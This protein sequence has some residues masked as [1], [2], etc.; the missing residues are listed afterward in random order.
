[1]IP[2]SKQ[3]EDL[4]SFVWNVIIYIYSIMMYYIII[5]NLNLPGFQFV[6]H[7]FRHCPAMN[8][9]KSAGFGAKHSCGKLKP[10]P[11]GRWVKNDRPGKA[12]IGYD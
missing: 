12:Q 2:N 3:F 8:R 7:H 4:D 11:T 6:S 5:C 10:R 9:R 1:M